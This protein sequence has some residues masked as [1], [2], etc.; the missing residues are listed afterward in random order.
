VSNKSI[1]AKV[2]LGKLSWLITRFYVGALGARLAHLPISR[3][4]YV[5][6]VIAEADGALTQKELAEAV[7][8]DKASMVRIIDYLCKNGMVERITDTDDRRAYRISATDAGR[9]SVKDI[10]K[11]F[12]EVNEAATE[13]F[14][15]EEKSAVMPLLERMACNLSKLPHDKVFIK[16][17]RR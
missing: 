13:G 14:A 1:S 16:I 9:K 5:L 8:T 4:F 17:D 11:A 2:P 15:L 12:E 7:W 3:H 6:T 10:R